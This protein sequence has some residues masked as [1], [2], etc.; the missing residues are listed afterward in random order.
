[1]EGLRKQ[2]IRTKAEEITKASERFQLIHATYAARTMIKSMVMKYYEEKCSVL[3]K[4]IEDRIEQGLDIENE[5]N[6][7]I[8]LLSKMKQ[9]S[10]HIDVEYIDTKSEDMARVVKVENA[11]VINLPKALALKVFNED[12]NYNYEIIQKIRR[13]MA[14]ELGHLI[15]HTDELLHIDGTQGSLELSFDEKEIEARYFAEELI[16]LRRKRNERLYKDRAYKSI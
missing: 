8:E 13:L 5:T 3:S 11:F 12:G 15:L 1:M 2:E 6:E 4:R 9:S 10:F 16:E 7:K 14:H